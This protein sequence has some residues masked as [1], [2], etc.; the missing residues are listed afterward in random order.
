MV[1]LRTPAMPVG[2]GGGKERGGISSELADMTCCELHLAVV[3]VVVV[4]VVVGVVV[5]VVVVV[6]V[7]VVIAVAAWSCCRCRCYLWYFLQTPQNRQI[8][9][10]CKPPKSVIGGVFAMFH[11]LGTKKHRKILMFLAPRERKTTVFTRFWAFAS[12]NHGIYSVLWHWY[13]RSFQHVV[14]SFFWMPKA[15]KHW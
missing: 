10:F 4:F 7:I 5:V 14:T 15:Q 13:L 8:D 2:V 9:G 1:E 12:K 3:V 6:V 11:V